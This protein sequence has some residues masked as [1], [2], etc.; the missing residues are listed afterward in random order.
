MR[1]HDYFETIVGAARGL[2][3]FSGSDAADAAP[4]ANRS[5]TGG[6]AGRSG[7]HP[8]GT[9]FLAA[10]TFTSRRLPLAF[11]RGMRHSRSGTCDAALPP[12]KITSIE[13]RRFT[14]VM[15]TS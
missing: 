14:S 2:P 4:G 13:T 7:E 1:A 3:A 11:R 15:P 10:N 6:E 12:V 9:A 5:P 8:G